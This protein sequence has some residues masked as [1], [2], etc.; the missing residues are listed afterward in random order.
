MAMLPDDGSSWVHSSDSF[1][2][3]DGDELWGSLSTNVARTELDLMF[4]RTSEPW[5]RFPALKITVDEGGVTWNY[6]HPLLDSPLSLRWLPSTSAAQLIPHAE[7]HARSDSWEEHVPDAPRIASMHATPGGVRVL[8]GRGRLRALF[9]L[10]ADEDPAWPTNGER[11]ALLA[12][13]VPK[14]RFFLPIGPETSIRSVQ[15]SLA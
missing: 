5:I 6:H 2:L 11:G 10:G 8:N 15:V 3:L 7:F 4:P 1:E 13:G 14:L 12:A 9:M